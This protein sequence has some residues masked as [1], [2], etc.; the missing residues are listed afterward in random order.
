MRV[1]GLDVTI[2]NP[3]GSFRSG[4]DHD[5]KP[6]RVRLQNHYGYIRGTIGAD[7]DHV[8]AYVGPDENSDKVFVID[9]KHIGTNKFDEHKVMLGFKN[10]E[11]A[12]GGYNSGSSDSKGHTRMMKITTMS[13]PEFKE[14]LASGRTHQPLSERHAYAAH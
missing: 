1:H 14:W 10:R 4:T 6:W 11:A 12:L 9:Q 7:G 13:I 3:K 5:G 2:E 8:D